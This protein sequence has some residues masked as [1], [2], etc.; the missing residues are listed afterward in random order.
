MQPVR[1][2]KNGQLR[3]AVQKTAAKKTAKP[4]PEMEKLR[5]LQKQNP[6][7]YADTADCR[8]FE[9]PDY[10]N[11][12]RFAIFQAQPKQVFSK[13]KAFLGQKIFFLVEAT[14]LILSVFSVIKIN[15]SR[16]NRSRFVY[17]AKIALRFSIIATVAVQGFCKLPHSAWLPMQQKTA[18]F[19]P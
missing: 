4:L 3:F 2:A 15:E 17:F 11:P 6:H 1:T 14:A 18:I 10:R 7:F 9:P 12:K 5:F 16:Q 13:L 19:L 8:R